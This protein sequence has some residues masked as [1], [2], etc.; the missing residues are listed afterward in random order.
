[1]AKPYDYDCA[2]RISNTNGYK[3][4][5]GDM[6]FNGQLHNVYE[7]VKY[8]TEYYSNKSE[9]P[10]ATHLGSVW[11][12]RRNN[13]LLGYVGST[14]KNSSRIRNGWVPMFSEKFQITDEIM[15]TLPSSRPVLGQLW[16]YNGLLMYYDGSDW[17]PV[18]T[19][20][21][22]DSQFN[23]SVFSD[24]HIYAPL[25]RLGSMI[26]DDTMIDA[27]LK[28]QEQYVRSV[29]DLEA[30]SRFVVR[31]ASTGEETEVIRAVDGTIY[32]IDTEGKKGDIIQKDEIAS[33]LEKNRWRFDYEW[34]EVGASEH[35]T[36]FLEG[37]Y[38]YLV[39]NISLDRIF[40]NDKL[41][42]QY[43]ADTRSVIKYPRSLIVTQNA[44]TK[45]FS[46]NVPSLVH[47]NPGKLTRIIKRT[48]KVDKENPVIQCSAA[49]TEYY[50]F[51][52]YRDSQG[53]IDKAKTR[54][55]HWLRPSKTPVEYQAEK[56][57]N[58][59]ELKRRRDD[60]AAIKARLTRDGFKIDTDPEYD[61]DEGDYQK[62]ADSDGGYIY[63]SYDASQ[64]YDYIVS[65]TYEFSWYKSTGVLRMSD[66]R[67]PTAA[68]YLPSYVGPV[69]VFINGF[70]YE[71]TNFEVN[72]VGKTVTLAEDTTDVSRYDVQFLR[73]LAHEYGYIRTEDLRV[74]GWCII[75]TTHRFKHPLVFVNGEAIMESDWVYT[76]D[77]SYST[78]FG[79][80][81]R[82]YVT[83]TRI[84]VRGGQRDMC[85]TVIELCETDPET[86]GEIV[87]DAF[88]KEGYVG[89]NVDSHGNP[90]ISVPKEG[91]EID[92]QHPEIVLFVNGLMI[93]RNDIYAENSGDNWLIT[94]SGLEVG[95][96]FI[97]LKDRIL[98]ITKDG[99]EEYLSLYREEDIAEALSIGA[100]D[101]TLVYLNGHFLNEMSSVVEEYPPEIYLS[102]HDEVAKMTAGYNEVRAFRTS[103]GS[104]V[105]KIFDTTDQTYGLT[106]TWKGAIDYVAARDL[107]DDF[108]GTS[109]ERTTK[110][111]AKEAELEF[112][113]HDK[114]LGKQLEAEISSF[115]D[116][117]T[118][119]LTTIS[120]KFSVAASDK[121]K[122]FGYSFANA[123]R[124]TTDIMIKWLHQDDPKIY[125]TDISYRY[126]RL[127]ESTEKTLF[128]DNPDLIDKYTD[129]VKRFCTFK[130]ACFKR[131]V[132]NAGETL[133]G[134]SDEDL[135]KLIDE[136]LWYTERNYNADCYDGVYLSN[137]PDDFVDLRT[138]YNMFK[139]SIYGSKW[140]GKYYIE[141]K[142]NPDTDYLMLWFNGVRQ[143][144][145]QDIKQQTD[146]GF[147]LGEDENGIFIQLLGLDKDGY[148]ST[149]YW[150]DHGEKKLQREPINGILAIVV[151]HPE[152]GN[153]TTARTIVLDNANVVNNVA[154]VYTTRD[155]SAKP[156]KYGIRDESRDVSMYPGRI[157]VYIDGIRV[158]PTMYTVV[159]NY[160]LYIND[161]NAT[162][163]GSESNFPWHTYVDETGAY[164]IHHLTPERLL[165]EITQ[166]VD[167]HEAEIVLPDDFNG[168]VNVYDKELGLDFGVLDTQDEILIFVDGLYPGLTM[169]DGYY[170]DYRTGSIVMRDSTVIE[171]VKYN[172]LEKYIKENPSETS[173]STGIMG[174]YRNKSKYWDHKVIFEWR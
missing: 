29:T 108:T 87:F 130:I 148:V 60:L 17:Q 115:C 13:E 173:W 64:K 86:E 44:D 145:T 74:D 23:T 37:Y 20:E 50:G 174:Y 81:T 138:T 28:R 141:T 127:I 10:E 72:S 165:V 45:L 62:M 151:Q 78:A 15:N 9:T 142:Y 11:Y 91:I 18:K 75:K 6:F 39:P 59:A 54:L 79:S 120:P 150:D 48:F 99:E 24:F 57:Q 152:E 139:E 4:R 25:N 125:Y 131:W 126:Q 12:D 153:A 56:E 168:S 51:K 134:I 112:T 161:E 16:I 149:E 33:V 155:Q 144:L 170:I 119:G 38:Q 26:V 8:L 22:T 14:W 104:Y 73:T 80:E 101:Q 69:N 83:G 96:S 85:W 164:K 102:T 92:N 114:E 135:E 70:D 147:S 129:Y 113:I 103:E 7:G 109:T 133:T 94:V 46:R 162:M 118:N 98:T 3:G 90:A 71:N 30:D 58:E 123:I 52:I 36:N 154:G 100:I 105:M 106:G 19:L 5:M 132:A 88:V 137:V 55:G 47:I 65:V 34:P 124:S 166:D 84:K 111:E 53:N 40:L 121:L 49:N 116:S 117:Y 35:I 76:E 110:A 43:I 136:Y 122:V 171:S 63:L 128:L 97:V 172:P 82:D 157:K 89:S 27:Y 61:P 31:L 67:I 143:Y 156:D 2:C 167:K 66:S 160:T 1:M 42:E 159:D 21:Q 140:N 95:M 41:D 163:L 93:R 68:Y 169:N 158:P 146:S 32:S 77:E 107:L